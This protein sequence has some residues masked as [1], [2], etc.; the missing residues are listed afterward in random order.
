MVET[1]TKLAAAI[2]DIEIP[3]RMQKLPLSDKGFPIPAFVAWLATDSDRYLPEGTFGARRDFRIVD[4]LYMDRCFRLTRCWLCGEPLG[5]Y[6]I[7]AIGPMCVVNRTTMEPP[8]HRHCAEYAVKACPFLVNPR[9]RRNLKDLPEESSAP[10]TMIH[11]NPGATALYQTND[12]R[13]FRVQNGM[14]CRLGAPERMEWYCEGR[15]A[16]KKEVVDSIESGMPLLM[17]EAQIDGPEAVADLRKM[18]TEARRW[19]PD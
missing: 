15:R 10:G 3:K 9:A 19:L 5:Q 4:P 2:A 8:S 6:R 17:K 13:R 14:L 12:Y 1:E 16:T 18:R 7:F 11:R